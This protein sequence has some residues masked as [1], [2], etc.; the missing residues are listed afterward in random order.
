VALYAARRLALA[1][2]VLLVLSIGAFLLV[3]LV[4]GSPVTLMLGPRANPES[5]AMLTA[6]FHLDAP[7]LDQY[8][9]FLTAALRLDLGDSILFRAPVASLLLPR[10]VVSV[11]LIVYGVL[12]SLLIAV[13]LGTISGLRRNR[14]T[15][16]TIRLLS[17]IAFGMPTFWLAL[18]LIL[19]FS[20]TLKLVPTSG[21]AQEPLGQIRA[22][23]LPA[24][25]IGLVEAPLLV[26]TL[27]ASVIETSGAEHVEA[28]R[29]RGLPYAVVVR[30]HILRGSMLSMITVL[31]VNIGFL[32]SW[33]VVV[34]TVF[35]LPGLGSALVTAVL[36]RDYP[37]ITGIALVFGAAVVLINLVTDLLYAALDPR[38][39]L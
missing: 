15:D 37:M 26:R 5:I 30:R 9:A 6:R 10:F 22:L 24:L 33:T 11:A 4:P 8:L 3:R 36:G 35:A 14:P 27:R 29:A 16:H 19:V 18:V 28:A 20:L 21:Y 7:W 23:T 17:T 31:G 1:L 12:I 39:R 2:P 32:L 34:E 13:P 38:V 25:V